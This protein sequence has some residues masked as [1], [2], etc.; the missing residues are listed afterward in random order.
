MWKERL[1]IERAAE[2]AMADRRAG[3]QLVWAGWHEAWATYKARRQD[4][5]AKLPLPRWWN[6]PG[7]IRWL[8][9][10]HAPGRPG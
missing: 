3:R 7:W 6:I 8:M 4:P 9:K 1:D 10:L 5:S 2:Q